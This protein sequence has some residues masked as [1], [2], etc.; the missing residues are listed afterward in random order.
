MTSEV[1]QAGNAALN[2][3][4]SLTL[5]ILGAWS[6][7]ALA[8]TG[9]S[10]NSDATL[11]DQQIG[12][13]PAPAPTIDSIEHGIAIPPG[14]AS[15]ARISDRAVDPAA[16]AKVILER[17]SE[18]DDRP[19][20]S[21]SDPVRSELLMQTDVHDVPLLSSPENTTNGEMPKISDRIDGVTNN[22]PENSVVVIRLPG[23][24]DTNDIRFRRQ[25]YRTDI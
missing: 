15:L 5:L 2:A 14:N 11:S 21:E 4:G 8:S 6:A 18:R 19:L 22:R 10:A 23:V 9:V 24:S 20:Q 16:G 3:A 12:A 17:S 25:M 7:S 13:D 1:A